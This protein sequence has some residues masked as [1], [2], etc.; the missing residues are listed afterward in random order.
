MARAR[1]KSAITTVRA[2]GKARTHGTPLTRPAAAAKPI[3]CLREARACSTVLPSKTIIFQN[4]SWASNVQ[5]SFSPPE[6]T[7]YN[8]PL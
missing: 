6:L 4:E 7:G 1:L 5:F 3:S 2:E 8:W